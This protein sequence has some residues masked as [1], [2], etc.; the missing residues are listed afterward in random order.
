VFSEAEIIAEI[1]TLK[2]D[3]EKRRKGRRQKKQ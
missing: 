1:Q 3:M 2:E